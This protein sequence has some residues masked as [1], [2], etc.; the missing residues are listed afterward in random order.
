MLA[1]C[2]SLVLRWQSAEVMNTTFST[3]LVLKTW[4]MCFG[5]SQSIRS[6]RDAVV[7]VHTGGLEAEGQ[8]SQEGAQGQKRR[9]GC[10]KEAMIAWSL[11]LEYPDMLLCSCAG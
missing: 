6:C 10:C 4:E 5:T 8:D 11:C 1:S 2:T 9:Q 7:H 3:F